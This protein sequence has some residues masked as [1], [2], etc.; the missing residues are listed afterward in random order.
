MNLGS[1]FKRQSFLYWFI[2]II[3]ITLIL[4][5]LIFAQKGYI[6]FWDLS[7]A[8]DFRSPLD[9][10]FYNNTSYD[11]Y[12]VG[13][14]N[15]LPIV[16]VF[17]FIFEVISK[18]IPVGVQDLS[19]IAV[20][21]MFAGAFSAFYFLFPRFIKLFSKEEPMADLGRN[22]YIFRL[23]ISLC[24]II[25]PFYT[26]RI[27]QFH[28]FFF[29]TFYPL[30]V[31]LFFQL[32]LSQRKLLYSSLFVLTLFFGMTSAHI[33]VYYALTF[34][35]LLVAGLL[36][37]QDSKERTRALLWV[38]ITAF[39]VLL[40]QLYWIIP[41]FTNNSPTPGYLVNNFMIDLLSQKA[42]LQNVLLDNSEW[43]LNQGDISAVS[44]ESGIAISQIVGILM[45]YT[46]GVYGLLKIKRRTLALSLIALL[47][48]VLLSLVKGTPLY[49]FLYS[50]VVYTRF[51]WV[52]R[53]VNRL[54]FI[55]SFWTFLFF[56]YGLYHV[57]VGAFLQKDK[58]DR[59]TS[60]LIVV[61]CLL[62]YG[63]FSLPVFFKYMSFLKPVVVA[64]SF[65]EVNTYLE[66]DKE[67]F[68]VLTYPRTESYRPSWVPGSFL[69]ADA[70]NYT[71]QWYNLTKPPVQ[72]SNPIPSDKAIGDYFA[73]Y[74]I[75]TNDPVR[76]S[77]LLTLAGVKYVVID[78][79]AVPLFIE[80]EDNL[81]VYLQPFT[82]L[83]GTGNSFTKSMENPDYVIYKNNGY[84]YSSIA[85]TGDKKLSLTTSLES[86]SG[87]T[88]NNRLR[89]LV[90]FPLYADDFDAK[91]DTSRLLLDNSNTPY[92]ELDYLTQ[93]QEQK[94][95]FYPADFTTAY[96][97]NKA[98]ARASAKD[99]VNG[100]FQSILHVHGIPNYQYVSDDKVAYSDETIKN[101]NATSLLNFEQRLSCQKNCLVFAKVLKATNGGTLGLS[102]DEKKMT[103]SLKKDGQNSSEFVWVLLKEKESFT[104][105]NAK[106]ELSNRNGFAAVNQIVVIPETEFLSL[107][108]T[109]AKKYTFASRNSEGTFTVDVPNCE[110]KKQEFTKGSPNSIEVSGNCLSKGNLSLK[111]Y[112]G[113]LRFT[114]SATGQ[115]TN[116]KEVSVV[117]NFDIKIEFIS[118]SDLLSKNLAILSFIF[119][120][121]FVGSAMFWGLRKQMV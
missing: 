27:S 86:L 57:Y 43:F 105:A 28:L 37:L 74:G 44:Q 92:L 102:I 4:F 48:V 90:D 77:N 32:V 25:I 5:I 115:V 29:S 99:K 75:E 9:Q 111:Y 71:F 107:Q 84:N 68:S 18:I 53:E 88:Q 82:R 34:V 17:Y 46:V 39:V 70:T 106:I 104:N 94:Y 21:F 30:V 109:F 55:W 97:L 22:Y 95:S 58:G 16:S 49:D 73:R 6:Y 23:I 15:R 51:G 81:K 60:L 98:W 41:Y 35:F 40:T 117:G 114:D 7:S 3:V 8:F 11:G 69:I 83:L 10:Y 96:G 42:T 13:L 101:K 36:Q 66:Q 87:L 93:D 120:I 24:Y 79:S 26:Y 1:L 110:I 62:L 50:S 20:F 65:K 45:V 38:A 31:Y 52:I 61:S 72:M 85:I 47:T 59:R 78:K 112:T 108:K 119:S 76:L 121:I 14:R 64:D 91:N 12:N 54:R 103:I 19:K 100:E 63:L 89:P 56:A 118:Q 113:I 2:G 116:G 67:Y 80:P 33:V